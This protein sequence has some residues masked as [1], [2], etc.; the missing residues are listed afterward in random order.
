MSDFRAA[1]VND[2]VTVDGFTGQAQPNLVYAKSIKIELANPL[3]GA[4]KHGSHASKSPATHTPKPK[5]DT[6]DPLGTG[7]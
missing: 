3:T 5:K 1:Q 4:K 7:K 6:D 2:R